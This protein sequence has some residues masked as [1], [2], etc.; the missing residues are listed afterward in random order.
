MMMMNALATK[1]KTKVTTIARAGRFASQTTITTRRSLYVSSSLS[2]SSSISS[3]KSS[4]ISSPLSSY[5]SHPSWEKNTNDST[6]TATIMS[7]VN[8]HR[9][10]RPS[11]P[12]VVVVADG[13]GRRYMST[14]S[15]TPTPTNNKEDDDNNKKVDDDDYDDEEDD[16][17][18]PDDDPDAPLY[19]SPMGNLISRL[20]IVSITSCV[21]S[22]VGLPCMIYIKNGDWPNA[23]QLGM[24]GIAF[25]GATGS[26]L[27]LHFVFGPYIL[28]MKEIP[29]VRECSSSS[30]KKES[31]SKKDEE[32]G[33]EKVKDSEAAT[34]TSTTSTTTT[35][36]TSTASPT[37]FEATT[38]SVFGWKKR[39][40]FD[41]MTDVTP[42]VGF[43]PFA[44]FV[45]KG[46]TPLYVHSELLDDVTRAKLLLSHLEQ[47]AVDPE[48][49]EE[50]DDEEGVVAAGADDDTDATLLEQKLKQKEEAKK[51]KKKK[52][53]EQEDDDFLLKKG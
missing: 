32:D 30:S 2:I 9:V 37:L 24:G 17:D 31:I 41:P 7:A 52:K 49:E 27:A 45:V 3:S 20:K 40:V 18:E 23:K 34:T 39:H 51:R 29:V 48:E 47:A 14:T 43:R 35:T 11:S 21:M 38:R 36:T 13:C 26:T 44:N 53:D 8:N 42:F 28:D 25:M 22:I 6:E 16:D 46:D 10:S 4:S 1:T 15:T 50:Y 33:E 19:T 5:F 12:F